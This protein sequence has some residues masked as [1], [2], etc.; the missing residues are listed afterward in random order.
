VLIAGAVAAVLLFGAPPAKACAR[1]TGATVAKASLELAGKV[2]A[3]DTIAVVRVCL[4]TRNPAVRIGSYHGLVTWDSTAAQLM[5]IDKG[6]MGMRLE[7]TTKSGAVDF[8]GAFPAG[9]DDTVALTLN[10]AL[11]K[12]G[13]LPKITLH[14]FELNSVSGTVMTSQLRV[15]GYPA[16]LR[17][18]PGP[19]KRDT[20]V[21]VART[22]S[23]TDTTTGVAPGGRGS[24]MPTTS[25]P[26]ITSI[27]QTGAGP[28][29]PAQAVIRGSGFLPTGN[30]V[31]F[32][33][34]EIGG[35]PSADGGT[36][37]RFEVP[38][39]FPATGE[40]PPMRVGPGEYPITVKNARGTS[41]ALKF[42]LKF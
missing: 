2:G 38:S 28:G 19:L 29:D 4:A 33:T 27:L 11:S 8:A 42:G 15:T 21:A 32:G 39:E 36:M 22:S 20:A 3:R 18:T 23:R 40:V 31:M 41:N 17:T 25:S 35:L 7:N 16:T 13:K 6:R 10:L 14:M 9:L 37:I 26:R 12:P 30:T 5:K 1:P 24:R 34:M